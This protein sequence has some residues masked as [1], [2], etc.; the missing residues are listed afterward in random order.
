MKN[1]KMKTVIIS[2]VS[3]ST[4]I[5]IFI[6]CLLAYINS[7]QILRQKINE[8]MSTYLDAQVNSVE[9]FVNEY[10]YNLGNSAEI[11]AKYIIESLKEKIK[12]RNAG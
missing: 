8:N 2:I 4:A 6:L 3:I 5:G 10:V 9:E 7:N 1:F 12:N 11:G